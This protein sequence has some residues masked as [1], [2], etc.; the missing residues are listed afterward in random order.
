MAKVDAW[1]VRVSG[2]GS[3]CLP[4]S[5]LCT[6]F[7]IPYRD[8]PCSVF[9]NMA[10]DPRWTRFSSFLYYMSVLFPALPC[11]FPGWHFG[12]SRFVRLHETF[13]T[14]QRCFLRRYFDHFKSQYKCVLGLNERSHARLSSGKVKGKKKEELQAQRCGTSIL[15]SILL[16]ALW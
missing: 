6:C 15:L 12:F 11:F 1:L 2:N 10:P 13:I 5:S 8:A 16:I 9:Y 4:E 14:R 3:F 7:V